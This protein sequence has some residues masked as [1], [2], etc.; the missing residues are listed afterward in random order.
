MPKH[1]EW[2]D[3]LALTLTT[4]HINQTDQNPLTYLH[5][6]D[7]TNP[8]QMKKTPSEKQ[9]SPY[10]IYLSHQPDRSETINTSSS[11]RLYQSNPDEKNPS[12][13]Q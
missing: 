10:P 4:Y 2:K 11:A 13:K 7:Y 1:A 5:Q 8:F 6:P 12:D 9:Y 3:S